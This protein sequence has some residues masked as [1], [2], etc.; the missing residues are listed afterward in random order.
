MTAEKK[1]FKS[2]LVKLFIAAALAL[3]VCGAAFLA[4]RADVRFRIKNYLGLGREHI[5]AM[6]VSAEEIKTESVSYEEFVGREN[7]SEN[8]A[9]MLINSENTLG[10]DFSPDISEYRQ[11]G[12]DMNSC[13]TE[14]YGKLS[15]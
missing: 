13:M 5:E 12:V 3:L 9:L 14:D 1:A 15:D 4:A 6:A 11:S 2:R 10:E 8:Q 7:V